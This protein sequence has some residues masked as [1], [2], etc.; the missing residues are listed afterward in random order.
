MRKENKHKRQNIKKNCRRSDH[1][2]KHD[3]EINAGESI[4][5]QA[6]HDTLPA[7]DPPYRN[8]IL[9]KGGHLFEPALLYKLPQFHVV[10]HFK[11]KFLMG[12][13]FFID[14][15]A[16]KVKSPDPNIVFRTGI[17]CRPRPVATEKSEKKGMTK[18]NLNPTFKNQL[19]EQNKMIELINF[20]HFYGS[21][22]RAF[23][24]N[25]ISIRKKNPF[26]A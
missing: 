17:P 24:K 3:A 23:I 15:T 20:G 2:K 25:N 12:A 14:A 21:H 10:Q 5:F 9:P 13:D 18:K 22:K 11:R 7:L 8:E 1:Q 19:R 26:A 4:F 6:F 16:Q